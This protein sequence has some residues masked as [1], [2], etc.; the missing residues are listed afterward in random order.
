MSVVNI[1]GVPVALAW[2]AAGDAPTL[3][4][5]EP[6][7]TEVTPAPTVAGTAPARTASFTPTKPG[8]HALLWATSGANFAD[9]LD[10]WPDNPRYLVSK[11]DAH[12][13]LTSE[14]GGTAITAPVW[15]AL[16]LY[17]ASATAVVEYE[18]GPIIPVTKTITQ[19]LTH[20]VRAIVLPDH[21]ITLTS[22]TVDGSAV[23][24][25]DNNVDDDAGIVHGD[26]V[27]KVVITYS[28]GDD[29]V[30]PLA[31]QACLEIVAHS[32]QS[33]RQSGRPVVRQDADDVAAT[34]AGYYVPKR[35]LEMLR[36]IGKLGGIA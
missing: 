13:R 1:V 12:A 26:F 6:D 4:I 36:R 22:V 5:I 9:V 18:T 34:S 28:T 2:S 27:G 10:V 14:G 20:P 11:A 29:I 19:V 35:A 33:T 32:W 3:Q 16:P 30:H 8:R 7:G 25:D 24:I 17:I 21:D 15:D 31:R 23:T